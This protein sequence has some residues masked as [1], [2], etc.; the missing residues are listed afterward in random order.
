MLMARYAQ[1]PLE[2]IPSDSEA[3]HAHPDLSRVPS[4]PPS[5]VSSQGRLQKSSRGLAVEVPEDSW[6]NQ[7]AT[8][9]QLTRVD[10]RIRQQGEGRCN[11][12]LVVLSTPNEPSLRPLRRAC[13]MVWVRCVRPVLAPC[14]WASLASS[15]L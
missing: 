7:P 15:D 6:Q 3:G 13:R 11:R 12:A 8:S 9:K 14:V 10:S 1:A 2:R 4:K 5:R